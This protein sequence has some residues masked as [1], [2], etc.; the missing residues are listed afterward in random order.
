MLFV[1]NGCCEILYN[2]ESFIL[3]KGDLFFISARHSYTRRPIN[4][5]ECTLHYIHFTTQDPPVQIEPTPLLKSITEIQQSLNLEAISDQPMQYPNTIYMQNEIKAMDFEKVRELI[6]GM[7]IFATDRN[8]MCG[9]QSQINLCNL[10]VAISHQTIK[11]LTDTDIKNSVSFPK[12]L[13]K[14]LNY[15]VVHSNKHITL[16]EL[17]EHCHVSKHQLIRYFKSSLNTTPVNYI[18]DYKIA[19][20]KEML[21]HQSPLSIKEISENLGFSSQYYF[22]KVFT[23]ATGETPSAYRKRT[24][25]FDLREHKKNTANF[26]GT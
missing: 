2:N 13:K 12:K 24:L 15:I 5:I 26:S 6:E 23:K 16:D 18:T 4:D 10:F 25:A 19:R 1:S 14:A 3:E 11:T 17:A 21:Y 7:N 9:L 20:A 22:T 8:L